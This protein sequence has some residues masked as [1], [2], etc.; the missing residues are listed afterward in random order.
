[1][2]L[3]PISGGVQGR[4]T[5]EVPG[6]A[7]FTPGAMPR[8]TLLIA[9]IVIGHV[10]ASAFGARARRLRIFPR[11]GEHAAGAKV[12]ISPGRACDPALAEKCALDFF[13]KGSG[14]GLP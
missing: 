1:M 6:F 2:G 11:V 7:S 3:R 4:Q 9:A 10:L 5:P 8:H 13:K 12:S 14:E